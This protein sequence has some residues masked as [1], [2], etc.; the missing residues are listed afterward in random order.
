MTAQGEL[1]HV[2]RK[3][4]SSDLSHL[5]SQGYISAET[6]HA[7]PELRA[8]VRAKVEEQAQVQQRDAAKFCRFV[9]EPFSP[10]DLTV[11][12]AIL[13]D[14]KGK[15]PRD[16]LPFFSKVNLRHYAQQLSRMGFNI[17]FAAVDAT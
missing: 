12:Y 1:I 4:G 10:S 5:F 6:I 15:P 2:K 17:A 13:A 11:V 9:K 3:L 14:W 8:A 7:G 16:R